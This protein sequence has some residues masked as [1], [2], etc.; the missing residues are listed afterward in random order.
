VVC[1]GVGEHGMQHWLQGWCNEQLQAHGESP[2]AVE[3]AVQ[4][5]EGR[6]GLVEQ[7]CS[8]KESSK[9]LDRAVR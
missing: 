9:Q 4:R 2:L 7:R 3:V 5:Q 1:D 6:E 8:A